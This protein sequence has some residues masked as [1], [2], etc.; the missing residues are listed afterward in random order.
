M[1]L[2]FVLR[3]NDTAIGSFVAQRR[4]AVVPANALCTYDVQVIVHDRVK[5]VVV[6]HYRRD[7]SLTL[8]QKALEA[9][10]PWVSD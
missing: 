2:H 7:G 8:V 10:G 5:N 4:E 9:V 6:K 3:I 1:A